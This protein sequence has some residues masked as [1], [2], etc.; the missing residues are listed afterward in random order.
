MNLDDGMSIALTQNYVSASNLPDVLRFLKTR[1]Q[2]ISGCRDRTD[3]IQPDEL[4]DTFKECLQEKHP[5]LLEKAQRIAEEGW[6]CAAWADIIGNHDVEADSA[7]KKT[8]TSVLERAR[9]SSRNSGSSIL[10]EEKK[11][12]DDDVSQQ[13]SGGFSFS[14]L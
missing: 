7:K 9:M 13:S 2:Q 1:K 3:A 14:F 5:D 12:G 10:S 11:V 8:K 6:Q 4:L